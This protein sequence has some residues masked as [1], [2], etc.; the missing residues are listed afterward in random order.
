M[1][2]EFSVLMSVYKS[3]KAEYL[4]RA[5]ESVSFEQTLKPNQIVLVID[6]PV[7][8]EIHKVILNFRTKLD[9]N[10]TFNVIAKEKNEGLAAALNTGISACTN[11]LIARMDSDDISLPERFELQLCYMEKHPQTAVL[12]GNILEFETDE[13]VIADKREVPSEHKDILEMLKTRNPIN[14]MSVMFNKNVISEIGGYCE[15]FGKLEDYK[16]WVDVAAK[17]Y[18][19]HNLPNNLVKARIG[20]GFLERR[21]NKREIEDWDRLQQYLL[22]LGMINKAKARKNRMYIRI[23][24]YMPKWIKKIV[25]KTILRKR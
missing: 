5:L 4:L 15:N 21:S 1:N 6:G 9:D 19:I 10:I 25:Y 2:K 22:S 3:D 20:D 8:D 14:H 11:E 18:D 12:G 13:N 17:N 16:L 7:D 23:F 24:T